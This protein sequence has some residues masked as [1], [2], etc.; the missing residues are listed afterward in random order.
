MALAKKHRLKKTRDIETVMRRSRRSE[1]EFFG[2]RVHWKP[3]LPG[4][5]TVIVSKKVSKKSYVRTLLKRRAV[6]WLRTEAHIA[7]VPAD[8]VLFIKPTAASAT[9]RSLVADLAKIIENARLR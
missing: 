4:R 2:L 8:C 6:E 5:A 7:R 3:A 1:G 9:K